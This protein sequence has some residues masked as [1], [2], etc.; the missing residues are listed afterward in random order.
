MNIV[1]I[2]PWDVPMLATMLECSQ[3][4]IR[5]QLHRRAPI[6]RGTGEM[7]FSQEIS[8]W[9][10]IFV[11]HLDVLEWLVRYGSVKQ[12]DNFAHVNSFP[13]W[14]TYSDAAISADMRRSQS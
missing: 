11:E 7:P 2:E 9:R 10:R 4:H 3:S 5:Q 8:A 14:A 6:L 13:D 1:E 12:K